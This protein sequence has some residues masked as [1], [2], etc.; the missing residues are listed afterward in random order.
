M[1]GKRC[2]ILRQNFI[3]IN[4]SPTISK[5]RLFHHLALLNL[6]SAEQCERYICVNFKSKRVR[7]GRDK[8]NRRAD[9]A[10]KVNPMVRMRRNIDIPYPQDVM[11]RLISTGR[12]DLFTVRPATIRRFH[13]LRFVQCDVKIATVCKYWRKVVKWVNGP[14]VAEHLNRLP[15]RLAISNRPLFTSQELSP[16]FRYSSSFT[17]FGEPQFSERY[18]YAIIYERVSVTK[19]QLMKRNK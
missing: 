1:V 17:S 16:T 10:H 8:V 7:V 13:A 15:P 18:F 19:F 6:K 11:Q 14:A 5:M 3:Q 4:E 9:V 12:P 2:L